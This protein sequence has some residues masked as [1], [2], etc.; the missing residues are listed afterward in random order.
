[1]DHQNLQEIK[2]VS[3]AAIAIQLAA[4]HAITSQ[5]EYTGA[6]ELL[7]RVKGTFKDVD[8]RE[9]KI[10]DPLMQSLKEA[11]DL[12]R[13]PKTILETAERSIKTQMSV[14]L[15]E[16]E[17]LAAEAQ[18]KANEE[19]ARERARLEAL[20]KKA[21]E[22]GADVKAEQFRERAD[23]VVA[24]LM[25]AEKPRVAGVALRK[26]WK[27]E[28]IDAKAINQSFCSPDEKKIRQTVNAMGL[29]A[30]TVI[31]PG[32]RIFEDQI[33]SARSM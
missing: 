28:I 25:V 19:A 29:D 6:V 15:R 1:M 21:E 31:G 3:D 8:E 20:A 32:V 22:R 12:F 33:V 11:R 4:Q 30:I 26:V 2:E 14:Y 16:Q 5:P 24:P 9:H 7:K 13:T 18:R 17:R 10:T 23:V 27:F